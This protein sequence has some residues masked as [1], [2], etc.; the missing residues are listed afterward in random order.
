MSCS[1]MLCL[2]VYLYEKIRNPG[3]GFADRCELPCGCW[4][5]NL[6]PLEEQRIYSLSISLAVLTHFIYGNLTSFVFVQ[7]SEYMTL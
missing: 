7:L 2:H 6:C 5:L 1:L 4:E 3:I